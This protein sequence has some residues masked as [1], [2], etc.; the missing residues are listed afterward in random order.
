[1]RHIVKAACSMFFWRIAAVYCG[2]RCH[3]K[4]ARDM[5]QIHLIHFFS[6]SDSKR[7]STS[8]LSAASESQ[9]GLALQFKRHMR[10][11][12]H[13][14]YVEVPRNMRSLCL[15]ETWIPSHT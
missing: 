3:G 15:I 13:K 14:F 11:Q 2:H 4:T 6:E 8:L 9:S 7:V 5:T 1:M 10:W 12:L